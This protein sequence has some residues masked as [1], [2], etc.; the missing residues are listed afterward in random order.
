MRALYGDTYIDE[1]ELRKIGINY[2][3]KLEYYITCRNSSTHN[4]KY[5][6]E[7]VKRSY[8]GEV[9][10]IEKSTINNINTNNNIVNN[11]LKILKENAVTPISAKEIVQDLLYA[12]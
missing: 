9:T 11:I 7:I 5:G 2:P 8:L 10:S 1:K 6:I 3:I 4:I 12:I